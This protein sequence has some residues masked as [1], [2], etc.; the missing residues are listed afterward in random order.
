M[1][2]PR[3]LTLYHAGEELRRGR[4]TAEELV[5]SCLERIDAREE[6]VQAWANRYGDA[7]LEQ[8]READRAAARHRWHGPLHGL[9]LGIKDIYDVAGMATEAGTAAYPSRIAERDADAVARLREAGAI[10]LGKTVTTAFATA[11]PSKTHNPWNPAHTPGG[12]SAGSGA[13]VADRMCGGALGTQTNGSVIRPA[14]YNGVVG[15]KP[16]LGRISMTGIIPVSWQL[17]HVGTFTRSVQDAALLWHLL[18]DEGTL[19]WQATRDKLP[20]ALLPRAP[21]RVWR[22]RDYFEAE[23]HPEHRAAMDAFCGELAARGVEIVERSLPPSFAGM[24]AAHDH[25]M[26]CEAAAVHRAAFEADPAP[27]PQR[28]AERIR[29]GLATRAVDYVGA[30]RHRLRL[31]DQMAAALADVDAAI[32]PAAPGPA[33]AGLESTGN[34][35]FNTLSSIC[36]LPAVC[37]PVG[38]SGQGLPLGLQLMGRSGQEDDLLSQGAWCESVAAF[39]ARPPGA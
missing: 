13:G 31:M 6:T 39:T 12:S 33:P 27:F 1:T 9:P 20:P 35:G 10:V 5:R 15:F 26:S 22:L 8:A 3:D 17:D 7:A 18:R 37:F 38:L 24:H 19:D 16:G 34:A 28:I 4:L 11:D 2:E 29:V 21:Q 25:I 23:A 30:L 32:A 36:G 14:S